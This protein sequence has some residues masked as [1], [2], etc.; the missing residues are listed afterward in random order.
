MWKESDMEGIMAIADVIVVN[1]G[2]HYAGNV[3]QFEEAMPLMFK[4]ACAHSMHACECTCSHA[5]THA[6][7]LLHTHAQCAQLEEFASRPGKSA[8]FRETN[9]EH[10]N[11]DENSPEGTFLDVRMLHARMMRCAVP[12]LC[13]D[14]LRTPST[15][16]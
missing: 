12:A 11:V 16:V 14:A 2:L 6:S 10:K 7:P 1:Y 4:Q 3:S 8:M 5:F 15:P 9:V 13:A